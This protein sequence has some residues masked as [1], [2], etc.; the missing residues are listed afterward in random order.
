MNLSNKL[1]SKTLNSIKNNN[2]SKYLMYTTTFAVLTAFLTLFPFEP[3]GALT[4]PWNNF[5][6]SLVEELRTTAKYLCIIGVM[7]VGV[8]Y[9]M[10]NRGVGMSTICK[11]VGGICLALSAVSFVAA[12]SDGF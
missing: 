7:F 10:N 6:A 2:T 9:A 5:L 3:A 1:K 12:I 4:L 8:G 11:L